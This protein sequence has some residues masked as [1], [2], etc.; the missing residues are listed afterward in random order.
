MRQGY[1]VYGS[2]CRHHDLKVLSNPVPPPSLPCFRFSISRGG[3]SRCAGRVEQLCELTRCVGFLKWA[4]TLSPRTK[5]VEG[6]LEL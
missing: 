1:N 5:A 3:T 2:N 6:I 4:R